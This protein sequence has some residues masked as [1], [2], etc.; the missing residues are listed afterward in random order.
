MFIEGRQEGLPSTEEKIINAKL[1]H[2]VSGR[3]GKATGIF[4]NVAK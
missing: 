2:C 4:N 3:K 1:S